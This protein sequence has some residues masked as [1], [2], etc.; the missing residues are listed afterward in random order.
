MKLIVWAAGVTTIAVALISSPA[1]A[2]VVLEQ[3]SAAAGSYYKAVLRITHGCNGSATRSVEVQL[4]EG[5]LRGRPMPKPGWQLH[6]KNRKLAQPQELHGKQIVEEADV[7]RWSGGPL[8]DAWYDEVVVVG[9]LHDKPGKLYF[10]VLQECEQGSHN[11][12]T[13]PTEGKKVGDY[14]E[15]AAELTVM[16]KEQ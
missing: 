3:R 16:P 9:R 11:W 13:I 2:H 5:F 10:K 6:V 1:L 15:P 4:P 14:P 7:I 12:S 8:P